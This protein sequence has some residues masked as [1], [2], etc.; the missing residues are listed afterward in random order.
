MSFRIT[1]DHIVRIFMPS[2]LNF[3][4]NVLWFL[5]KNSYF[6]NFSLCEQ[7]KCNENWWKVLNWEMRFDL[8][9]IHAMKNE[10]KMFTSSSGQINQLRKA[11]LLESIYKVGK[12]STRTLANRE[13]PQ[14]ENVFSKWAMWSSNALCCMKQHLQSYCLCSFYNKSHNP[15]ELRQ[16]ALTSFS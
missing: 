13:K 14:M 8:G 4:M 6:C 15:K 10:Q 7:L 12:Q 2:F 1:F 3:H 9:G 5:C 11:C 16:I